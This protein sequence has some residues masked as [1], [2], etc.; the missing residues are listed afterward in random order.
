MN[1]NVV[2]R[3]RVD[4]RQ[5]DAGKT[6][7]MPTLPRPSFIALHLRPERDCSGQTLYCAA[8]TRLH[9]NLEW[10]WTEVNLALSPVARQK[11]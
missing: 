11:P 10:E 7:E 5:I 6:S 4:D 9:E 1:S 2:H 8:K 3:W